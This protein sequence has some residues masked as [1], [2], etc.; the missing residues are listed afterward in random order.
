MASNIKPEQIVEG[1]ATAA[2]EI[3][4]NFRIVKA[5]IE[6]LQAGGGVTPA[7]LVADAAGANPT[8]AEFDA[9][10]TALKNAGL[11]ESA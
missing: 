3:R 10:L 1:D 7:A 4:E 11:M 9:L 2:T 6:A 5:E 8:K